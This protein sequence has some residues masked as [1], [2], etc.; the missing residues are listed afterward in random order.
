MAGFEHIVEQPSRA[1]RELSWQPCPTASPRFFRE[2]VLPWPACRG[3]LT[4]RPCDYRRL[5]DTG[6]EVVPV[7]PKA[8]EIE[9][10][11]C[12]PD[13][14]SIPGAIDGVVIVTPPDAALNL[15]RQCADKGVRAVWFHRSF[16]TGSV[17]KDAVEEC[18][19]RGIAV[20]EGGCPMMYCEPVDAGHRCIRWW[21]RLFGRVPG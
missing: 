6:L 8:T 11:R 13:L 19:A 16:G 9:G 5:R 3:N 14:A 1:R 15:V 18:K 17:S 4:R 12:Y 21:L 20:I 10:V 7:N 2:S